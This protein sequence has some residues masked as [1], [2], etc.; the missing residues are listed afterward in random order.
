MIDQV[1]TI[2]IEKGKPF[3]PDQ[4]TQEILNGAAREAQ[5]LLSQRYD[6]GFPVINPGINWFPAA[7]ADVIKAVQSGYWRREA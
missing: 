1:K 6:E 4:K 2:G 7:M 5:A 3:N